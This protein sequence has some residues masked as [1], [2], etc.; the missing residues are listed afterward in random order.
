VGLLNLLFGKRNDRVPATA[1]ANRGSPPAAAGRSGRAGTPSTTA[2]V[3]PETQNLW[4]W[5]ESGQPRAWVEAREGRWGHED[6]LGLLDTLRRSRFW[7]MQPEEVGRLLE[8]TKQVWLR[9]Q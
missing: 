9:R 4:R 1:A 7:P 2:P 6:W 5:R 8:D 3:P